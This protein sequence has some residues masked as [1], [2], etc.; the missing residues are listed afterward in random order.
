MTQCVAWPKVPKAAGLGVGVEVP[1]S[2]L[3]M[4]MV[5]LSPAQV[6]SRFSPQS[7]GQGYILTFYHLLVLHQDQMGSTR[8]RQLGSQLRG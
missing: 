3:G 2:P 4:G 5:E 8:L 7:W 1:A 6:H